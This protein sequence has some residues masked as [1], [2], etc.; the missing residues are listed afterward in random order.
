MLA[1]HNAFK[2]L[3]DPTRLTLFEKLATTPQAV[4]VLAR[5]MAVSRPA[6]SQ[7]LQVLCHAQLVR[8]VKVGNRNQYAINPVGMEALRAYVEGFWDAAL[9]SFKHHAES[10]ST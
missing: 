1:Y 7:H 5:G 9:G 4:G 6:V 2:A 3:A 10:S 8:R